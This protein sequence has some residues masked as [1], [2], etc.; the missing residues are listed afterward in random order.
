MVSVNE[1][2]DTF[3]GMLTY[4]IWA[5]CIATIAVL[6]AQR[7]TMADPE[8]YKGIH[9]EIKQEL[10][11]FANDMALA[12][13]ENDNQEWS[14]ERLELE[15]RQLRYEFNNSNHQETIHW[16]T[17]QLANSAMML[18]HYRDKQERIP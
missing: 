1:N 3:G 9:P 12:M 8:K 2:D 13:S 5:I 17:V 11:S 10:R 14:I 16:L 15:Y 4:L 6:L 7:V 18:R